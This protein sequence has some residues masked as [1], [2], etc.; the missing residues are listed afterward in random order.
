MGVIDRG[1]KR[2][3]FQSASIIVVLVSQRI[4]KESTISVDKS[5]NR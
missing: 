1:I 4:V 2:R 3:Y 5:N